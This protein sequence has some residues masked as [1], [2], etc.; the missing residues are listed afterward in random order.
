MCGYAK[1]SAAFTT[2]TALPRIRRDH[3]P[4]VT[5]GGAAIRSLTSVFFVVMHCYEE[6]WEAY[7]SPKSDIQNNTFLMSRPQQHSTTS[8][9]NKRRLQMPGHT[10]MYMCIVQ[11]TALKSPRTL[12]HRP[13]QLPIATDLQP[14]ACPLKANTQP[15]PYQRSGPQWYVGWLTNTHELHTHTQMWLSMKDRKG[16][17]PY[18][19]D[20][21]HVP[22]VL[23][24]GQH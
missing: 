18:R 8:V 2:S 1:H 16:Q 13:P 7:L 17:P 20:N 3:I 4:P 19:L 23:C 24:Y 6:A 5:Q 22:R 14:L 15:H 9:N 12:K 11:T 10:A 21:K